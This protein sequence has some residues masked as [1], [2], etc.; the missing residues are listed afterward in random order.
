MKGKDCSFSK[1]AILKSKKRMF[2]LRF[3]ES[4]AFVKILK[5]QLSRNSY[6]AF[7]VQSFRDLHRFFHQKTPGL[8]SP[9][10]LINYNSADGSFFKKQSRRNNTT[11]SGQHLG[12]IFGSNEKVL[13]SGIVSV[14]IWV[15]A[16][17]LEDEYIL[18]QF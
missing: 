18:T 8:I 15:Q 14:N 11:V 9:P 1:S 2:C 13:T 17:L 12:I 16:V 5:M 3:F 10:I 6:S 4:K 7:R